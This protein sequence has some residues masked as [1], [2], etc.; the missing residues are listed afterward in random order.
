MAKT[1]KAKVATGPA[2]LVGELK[3]LDVTGLPTCQEALGLYAC[4]DP[5][6]LSDFSVTDLLC[7][8]DPPESDP[9]AA[10]NFPSFSRNLPEI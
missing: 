2:I 10:A 9:F 3:P 1:G 6:A 8:C 5:A 7:F 4:C